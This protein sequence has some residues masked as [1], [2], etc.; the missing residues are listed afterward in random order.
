VQQGSAVKPARRE[1]EGDADIIDA[2]DE[3]GMAMVFTGIRHFHHGLLGLRLNGD[4]IIARS[5][6]DATKTGA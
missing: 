6:A 2:I 4:S 5:G 3:Y 1:E